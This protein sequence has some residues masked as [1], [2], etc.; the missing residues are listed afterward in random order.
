MTIPK[1]V[2]ETIKRAQRAIVRGTIDVELVEQLVAL[3]EFAWRTES[4]VIRQQRERIDALEA[5][6]LDGN[7]RNVL[8]RPVPQRLE[9]GSEV[10]R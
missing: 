1:H 2:D 7:R 9:Q 5:K 10:D 4:E 6:L 3:A 8:D